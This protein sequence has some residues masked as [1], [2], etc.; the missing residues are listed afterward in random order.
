MSSSQCALCG[1]RHPSLHYGD[2]VVLHCL[3]AHYSPSTRKKWLGTQAS[4]TAIDSDP[5]TF[6]TRY[7]PMF[8]VRLDGGTEHE[9]FRACSLGLVGRAAEESV[10]TKQA[11]LEVPLEVF[12]IWERMSEDGQSKDVKLRCSD[13]VDVLAHRALLSAASD[14][15]RTMLAS[16]MVEGCTQQIDVGSY[17]ARELEF[18]LGLLYT[19]DV[20]ETA[21]GETLLQLVI[22]AAT[23]FKKYLVRGFLELMVEW[24]KKRVDKDNFT[25]VLQFAIKED[26]APMRLFCSRFAEGVVEI[27][28]NFDNKVYPPEI[29]WELQ[30]IW[31]MP[32]PQNLKKRKA[33]EA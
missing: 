29:M 25:D 4:I 15:F 14:V 18:I 23:F 1:G 28:Q 11:K 21:E 9:W 13:G 31:P 32:P 7:A 17:S 2:R 19:G 33:F 20:V 3:P 8:Q 16:G 24:L 27:R 30:A 12:Q 22:A 6:Q 5:D 10:T 26:I